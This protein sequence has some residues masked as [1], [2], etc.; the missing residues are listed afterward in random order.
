[1]G[2]PPRIFTRYE[3]EL[4]V[5][6]SLGLYGSVWMLERELCAGIGTLERR[7]QEL[8]VELRHA[9][10]VGNNPYSVGDDPLLDRLFQKHG[11]RRYESLNLRKSAPGGI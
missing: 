1:M 9:D 5:Q 3:D 10:D 2:A 11:D 7:A 4:I 6:Q 8:G